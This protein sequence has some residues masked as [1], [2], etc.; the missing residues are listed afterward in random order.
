M[1]EGSD[2]LNSEKEEAEKASVYTEDELDK[3]ADEVIRGMEHE[4]PR[5]EPKSSENSKNKKEQNERKSKGHGLGWLLALLILVFIAIVAVAIVTIGNIRK[6]IDNMQESEWVS[7]SL[8]DSGSKSTSV[9]NMA[10]TDNLDDTSSSLNG[11]VITDVSGVVEEVMP[12]VVSV[13][14]RTLVNYYYNYGR[15]GSG[16]IWDY[17]FGGGMGGF[18]RNSFDLNGQALADS[19]GYPVEADGIAFGDSY[20]DYETE[21]EEVE[22]GLGSGT[23]IGQN[24]SELLILTSY[25]VVE[26][27]SSLY[28]TF[29]N[30]ESVDGYIKAADED[31]DIAV[32][33]V[34]L[35][36]IDTDT[37]NY[38][39][40]ATMCTTE[41]KVGEGV[42]VIGNALGYGMSVTTGIVSATQ[43]TIVVDDKT[44][45][46]IQTD[47]AINNGNS[48]GCMLNSNG[49]IIG[50]SEAKISTSAVEGMCYAIPI[51]Q[52]LESIKE[53]LNAGSSEDE[54]A[55]SEENTI[56]ATGA[57]L[58]IRG[59]DITSEVSD[60]YEMPQGVYISSVVDGS[61]AQT[62]GLMAG[63]IIVGIDD[64]VIATMDDINEELQ[65]HYSGDGVS[66]I[67]YRMSQDGYISITVD[68]TLSD[69]LG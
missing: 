1:D 39:K 60:T 65:K 35:K 57:G 66:V 44:I 37:L 41:A 17:F 14:S 3:F 61:G 46:V 62:A 36:D 16:S 29:M 2:R 12:S 59:R 42:I 45:T 23:I 32:V 47:A 63:D 26:D 38:I 43:R 64:V 56:P 7:Y 9:V 10:Q 25:H 55:E 27:C 22:S 13:T 68:V 6:M 30:D 31:K 40:I 11:Y 28:V 69:K 51:A 20:G 33:A 5:W 48:G 54:A 58:G 8:S 21:S 19:E 50:I 34:P 53:L 67:I 18:Q 24:S 52:N 15:N 49:E 4:T